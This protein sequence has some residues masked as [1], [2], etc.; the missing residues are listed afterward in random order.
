MP[1]QQ[2]Y[3][4][5]DAVDHALQYLGA[6]VTT[7]S[8]ADAR[9]AVL[10]ALNNLSKA[11]P[12]SYFYDRARINTVAPYSTGT[13]TF[14]LTGGTYERQLS[15]SGGSWPT[16]ATYGNVVIGEVVYE[17]AEY[18]STSILTLAANNCPAEDVAAGTSYRLYRDT[19]NLPVGF[20]S[21]DRML[22]TS[23]GGY[24]SYVHPREWLERQRISLTTGQPT[25][26][27]LTGDP[28]YAGLLAVRFVP[29]PDA[30]YAFDALYQRQPRPLYIEEFK[31]G[32]VSV[33]SGT[34]TVTGT[35]TG[36]TS[37]L[38]GS[39]IRFGD[40]TNYPTGLVGAYPYQYERVIME[41]T[42][43][44]ALTL[45]GVIPENLVGVKY[46]ISDPVDIEPVTMLTAFQRGVERE[47]AISKRMKDRDLAEQAWRMELTEAKSAEGRI[48][49]RRAAGASPAYITR[50]A[51]M[52]LG[53]D[54]G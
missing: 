52:P 20:V 51:D 31:T 26:W 39:V 16:W 44:T 7:Q 30:A 35:G 17:V 23:N 21:C 6:D 53:P 24:L 47:I 14:D 13:V 1:A 15:L 32:T 2:L 40:T 46:T 43:A 27:T 49:E 3:T 36:W 45:D 5:K 54:L 34:G 11:H 19:Y 37:K 28:N 8:R 22:N 42:S 29:A 48:L 50:L 41:V 38:A 9:A 12:W 4:Y 10:K 25:G 33:S 18:I